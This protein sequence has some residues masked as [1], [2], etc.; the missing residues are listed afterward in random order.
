MTSHLQ[1]KLGYSNRAVTHAHVPFVPP[2]S[3]I[4]SFRHSFFVNAPF[5]WNTVPDYSFTLSSRNFRSAEYALFC[6]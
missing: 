2:Q 6:S 4:N 3:T 1:K 5:L